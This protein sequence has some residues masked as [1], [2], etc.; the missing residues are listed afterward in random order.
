MES[1]EIKPF[2]GFGEIELGMLKSEVVQ[3]LGQPDDSEVIH[4]EDGE[5]PASLTVIDYFEN[6]LALYFEDTEDDDQFLVMIEVENHDAVM[7]GRRIFKMKKD[8]LV[9]TIH[10]QGYSDIIEEDEE[11][12]TRL[13]VQDALSEFIFEDNDLI[14]VRIWAE[15][16]EDESE[17]GISLN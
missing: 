8:T 14:V 3:I 9:K 12:E 10:E 5:E 1:L 4:D 13:I 16:E 6:G 7:F 11:D 17:G 15:F 2:E